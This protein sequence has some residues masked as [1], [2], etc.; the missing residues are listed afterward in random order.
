MRIADY[1]ADTQEC[2]IVT[3]TIKTD[4]KMTAFLSSRKDQIKNGKWKEFNK[5]AVLIAEGVFLNDTKHGI[6][7]EYFDTGELMI[8]EFY[9][10]GIQHGRFT[11]FH[12]NG[13]VWSE[14]NYLYGSREGYFN[15]YNEQGHNIRR[16]LF[17]NNQKTEDID[18]TKTVPA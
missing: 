14:G 2:G 10:R 16:L 8:E 15:V 3:S 9:D 11:S 6:W 4:L 7:R 5:H 17:V 1:L 13:Q 18:L 12:P